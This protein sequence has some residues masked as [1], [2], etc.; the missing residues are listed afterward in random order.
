MDF[1]NAVNR[2]QFDPNTHFCL[3]DVT[4]NSKDSVSDYISKTDP[5]RKGV[6]LLLFSTE[7]PECPFSALFNIS[8]SENN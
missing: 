5:A 2:Q 3:N 8:K 7:T 4:L 1:F 6:N